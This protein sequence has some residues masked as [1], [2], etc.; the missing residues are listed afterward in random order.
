MKADRFR[1]VL[2][3]QYL[4]LGFDLFINSFADFFRDPVVTE[5]ILYIIQDVCIIFSIII[6]FLMFF[7]TYIFRAGLVGILFS[8]FKLAIGVSLF[9]LACSISLHI[10]ILHLRWEDPHKYIWTK[11]L[12]ILYV[13]QRSGAVFYYYLYKRTALKVVDPRYYENSEWLQREIASR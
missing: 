9:Y 10:W 4:L 1:P 3:L 6:I 12:L 8:R 13:I 2:C 5:L 11:G 7:N